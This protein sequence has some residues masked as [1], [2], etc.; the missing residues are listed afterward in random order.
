[1]GHSLDREGCVQLLK[2]RLSTVVSELKNDERRK[3]IH[4][5]L[6]IAAYSGKTGHDAV[7]GGKPDKKDRIRVG[8]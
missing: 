7:V 5:Q 6:A 2:N 1:M 8:T 4:E 3:L